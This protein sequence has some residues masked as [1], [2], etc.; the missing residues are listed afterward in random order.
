MFSKSS[1]GAVTISAEGTGEVSLLLRAFLTAK[2]RSE[3]EEDALLSPHLNELIKACLD[4]LPDK[5]DQPARY[6]ADWVEAHHLDRVIRVVVASDS[7]KLADPEEASELLRAALYPG[8]ITP[9]SAPDEDT[10]PDG[11]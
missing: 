8:V 9:L 6:Y 11:R 2:F 10:P 4:A 7:Y 3:S 5:W 1:I